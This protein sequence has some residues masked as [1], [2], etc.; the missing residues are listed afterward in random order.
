[1]PDARQCVGPADLEPNSAVGSFLSETAVLNSACQHAE[2]WQARSSNPPKRA[3]GR[4]F[5]FLVAC[6]PHPVLFCARVY[7]RAF[8]EIEDDCRTSGL[9]SYCRLRE[10]PGVRRTDDDADRGLLRSQLQSTRQRTSE[11][12]TS[13]SAGRGATAPGR[14]RRCRRSFPD[15]RA[16]K[17]SFRI[18]PRGRSL[19]A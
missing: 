2:R 12:S 8:N 17:Q 9:C 7:G 19:S 15:R 11:S 13:A 10:E 3:G 1:M 4:A 5:R 6:S 14:N 16:G 18:G